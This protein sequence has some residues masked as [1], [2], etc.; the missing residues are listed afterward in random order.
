MNDLDKSREQLIE[1]LAEM[2]RSVAE[3]QARHREEAFRTLTGHSADCIMVMGADGRI[4]YVSASVEKMR[5]YTV[6]EAKLQSLEDIVTSEDAETL[7]V[8][9]IEIQAAVKSGSAVPEFRRDLK[10]FC[11]DGSMIWT[12]VTISAIRNAA[13]EFE[14]TLISSRDISDRKRTELQLKELTERFEL[15]KGIAELGIW[16]WNIADNTLELDDRVRAWYGGVPE[17]VVR[18]VNHFEFW[19][20]RIHPDDRD[21]AEAV[22]RD[23][24]SNQVGG[25][26]SFRILLPDGSVRHVHS[27]WVFDRD[28]QGRPLRMLGINRDVTKQCELEESLRSEHRIAELANAAKAEFLADISHEIRTQMNS[29]IGLTGFLL[30]SDLGLEQRRHAEAIY[31]SGESLLGLLT[32]ILDATTLETGKLKLEVAPFDLRVMLDDFAASMLLL[33]EEKR[34][35]FACTASPELP[36]RLVGDTVRLRQILTNLTGN[37]LKSTTRGDVSVRASLLEE[38]ESEVLIRF[39]VCDNSI[40]I[41]PEQQKLLFAKFAPVMAPDACATRNHRFSGLGMGIAKGLAESMGG[42]MGVASP[43]GAGT[44]FWFTVRLGK[45]ADVLHTIVSAPDMRGTHILVVHENA[46]TRQSLL[47]QLEA[48]DMRAE[49]V[50]DGLAAIQ[51]FAHACETGDPFHAAIFDSQL[52]DMDGSE[53]AHAI[54]ANKKLRETR[55][56][57]LTSLGRRV[58]PETDE[59][60]DGTAHLTKPIRQSDLFDCLTALANTQPPLH[61]AADALMVRRSHTRILVAEDN[62]VN[63]EV[64]LGLLRKLGLH[65]DAVDDGTK[66]IESLK[67]DPYDLVLMDVEMPELDG[68]EATRI[69][70]DPNSDVR[71]HQVPIIAMTAAAMEGDRERCLEA[72]MNG[73]IS[74]PVSPYDLVEA[75]NN[76][77]PSDWQ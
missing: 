26:N 74:K 15:A 10:Q 6:A 70:R 47:N 53:L 3:D 4:S 17:E 21:A 54:H 59:Y 44:E 67:A 46:E 55:L 35:N 12:D 16:S 30:E 42:E 20:S 1:E 33:A 68:L 14:G 31:A 11:K 76:W 71:N 48:W 75:L 7:R 23:A 62:I 60:S 56:V 25:S 72:G 69:I 50:A 40:V 34:I 41:S 39:S 65:A 9:L 13:G 5:G 61:V 58:L 43:V 49:A 64:A 73:Y 77:L 52:P 18:G 38:T 24:I 37:A 27:A 66:A 45:P 63:Q 57:L 8:D 19:R 28:S 36:D 32:D 51:A 2:R 29:V 22:L